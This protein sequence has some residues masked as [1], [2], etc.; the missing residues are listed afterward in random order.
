MATAVSAPPAAAATKPVVEPANRLAGKVALITGGTR[1]VGLAVAKAYVR[2]GA[3]VVVASR[4][5]YELRQVVE[6]LKQL[7]GN[8]VGAK[9]DLTNPGDADALYTAAC[10]AFGRVDI[11]V[12]N[13]AMLGARRKVVD[14]T[15]EEW[16]KVID[17]NLTSVFHVTRA[18]LGSMIPGNGGSI[19]NVT[20]SVGR[21]GKAEW[22]AYAV[23]KGGIET[24]TQVLADELTVYNIRANTVDPGAV[25]SQIRQLA[26]PKEDPRTLTL[27]ENIVNVFIYLASDASRGV[28]GMQFNAREWMGRSF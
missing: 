27:P 18:A 20:S 13:A 19:I 12:N 15:N 5:A 22:G 24:F 7:G 26:F 11:L 1:G 4:T 28:S 10:R 6:S 25:R 16:Q 8:A 17:T 23:S 14:T 2:E 9:A 21:Q 3:K